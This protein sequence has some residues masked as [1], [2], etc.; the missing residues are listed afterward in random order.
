MFD[1]TAGSISRIYR[2]F[3][4][5]HHLIQETGHHQDR[6]DIPSLTLGGFETWAIVLIKAYPS[7][8]YERIHKAAGYFQL[9][10]KEGLRI[11][12]DRS[13]FPESPDVGI[14]DDLKRSI[15]ANTS[16]LKFDL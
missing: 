5:Q 4:C 14:R 13:S 6:P 16:V 9:I 12:V 15:A 8:E 3:Q 2:H 11:T 1:N 7:T 10:D